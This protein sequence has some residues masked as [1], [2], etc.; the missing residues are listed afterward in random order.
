VPDDHGWCP[1]S[2]GIP[3]LE[4]IDTNQAEPSAGFPVQGRWI[5]LIRED[6]NVGVRVGAGARK[7]GKQ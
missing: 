6:E 2:Q 7:R 5:V 1:P 4:P 3:D